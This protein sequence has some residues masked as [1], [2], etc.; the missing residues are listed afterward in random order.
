M[1]TPSYSQENETQVHGDGNSTYSLQVDE[2]GF[3]L[4][5]LDGDVSRFSTSK[6]KGRLKM[7]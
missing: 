1:T 7:N 3:A 4:C 5:S 6:C 2:V